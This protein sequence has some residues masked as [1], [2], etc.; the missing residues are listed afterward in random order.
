MLRVGLTGG[1]GCGKTTVSKLFE[2]LNVPVYYADIASK[3]LYD[4]DAVVKE[5][6]IKHFGEGVYKGNKIDRSKLAAIV[7]NDQQKLELLNRIVHPPTIRNAEEWMKVQKTPYLIKEA[8]LL[9]ESGTAGSLDY[10]I[11]VSCPTDLRIKRVVARDGIRK[12][13]VLKRINQQLDEKIKMKLCDF[14]LY[15]DEEQLLIKQVLELHQAL[16]VLSKKKLL[17]FT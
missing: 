11:G 2:L 15:N 6:V 8:A 1:I 4:T 7:F 10:I 3:K 14:I 9:F 16:L 5:Q 12:E 17:Q 13:E